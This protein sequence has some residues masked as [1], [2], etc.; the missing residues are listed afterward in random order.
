MHHFHFS[1]LDHISSLLL[2]YYA[3]RTEQRFNDRGDS[4]L[5]FI[6]V[7]R[8]VR[9]DGLWD[10]FPQHLCRVTLDDLNLKNLGHC[11]A[12]IYQVSAGSVQLR[13]MFPDNS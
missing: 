5:A 12:D 6:L 7:I 1:Y 9:Y 3:V 2:K 10:N 11:A 4:L 8:Y 13:C